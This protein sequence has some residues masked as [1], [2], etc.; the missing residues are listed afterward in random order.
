MSRTTTRPA[1]R[2][3]PARPPMDDRIRQRRREIHRAGARRR[4]RVTLS[5]V[6]VLLL[7]GGGFA[8]TRSPLFA[9]TDVRVEGVARDRQAEVLQVAQITKGQNLL[10]ANLDAAVA[11]T[12]GL[13]WVRDAGVRREPPSTV[14]LEVL[15]RHPA[16]IILT[17]GG[18]WVVDPA[19]V[20]I[21]EAAGETLPRI[22]VGAGVVAVPG[23]EVEDPAARNA[24]DLLAALPEDV[25]TATRRIQAVG[26]A[27]VRLRL[28]LADLDDPAGYRRPARVWARMGTAGDVDEQVTVLRA[29]LGQLHE[30]GTDPPSEIDVR[31]PTNPVV[32]P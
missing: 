26:A 14:V 23:I 21:S 25:R 19:G 9:I 24:L 8:I 17:T 20:V 10:Q 1:P 29:L 22:E 18:K 15:P 3:A 7:L 31:V 4:R 6:M 11:R 12:A 5:V 32:I 2:R 28:A 13:P 30:P 27:T 16:A